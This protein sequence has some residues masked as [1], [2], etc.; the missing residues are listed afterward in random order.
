MTVSMGGAVTARLRCG[1]AAPCIPGLEW[2][3]WDLLM[4]FLLKTRANASKAMRAW[5]DDRMR[6]SRPVKQYYWYI[7]N[8]IKMPHGCRHR[9]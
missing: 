1:G 7:F 2:D 5:R 3:A 9:H 6:L 4:T 8:W